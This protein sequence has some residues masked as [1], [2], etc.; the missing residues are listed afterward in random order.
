MTIVTLSFLYAVALNEDFIKRVDSALLVTK[1]SLDSIYKEWDIGHYPLF[2]RSCFM[3]KLA[4]E[5]MKLKFQHRMLAAAKTDKKEPT[6]FVISFTGSSVTAGHDSHFNKSTPIV[7]GDYLTPAFAAMD[8]ELDSRNVA[9]GNNPCTPYDV[10]V[11]FFAGLDADMVHWEQSYFCEGRPIIEQFIRQ[12]MA[13]P[14]KPLV[15][16]SESHTGKWQHKDCKDKPKSHDKLTKEEEDILRAPN[17]V[18]LVSEANKV[19]LQR[20]WKWMQEYTHAYHGAGLQLFEHMA[21]DVYACQGPYIPTW[22]EGAASWHPS[23]IGHRMRAAHHA[24]FWLLGWQEALQDLRNQS[25]HRVMEAMEKDVDHRL[26]KL[27]TPMGPARHKSEFPDGAN[28]YTDYEPRPVREASLKDRVVEGLGTN[29][30]HGW[31]FVIY[32]NLVDKNLVLKTHRMQYKDFKHLIYGNKDSGPLSLKIDLKE[33]GPIFICETP[34]IWGSLPKGFAHLWSPT[35]EVYMTANVEN[36]DNFKFN[37]ELGVKYELNYDK[38]HEIC[39]R[40]QPAHTKDPKI[41]AGNYVLTIVGRS[42]SKAIIAWII[43]P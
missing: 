31:K 25:S 22:M 13:M 27:I 10:C 4:W 32:E 15:I 6:K 18:Y 29:A 30:T 21:H 34:G 28:C 19:S 5:Q 2:L 41:K 23:V 36:R 16:F 33:D 38:K 14:S 39:T 17:P 26:N 40:I 11:K 37:P 43:T 1:D 3:H 8:I 20:R 42:E 12:A 35:V 7:A 9:L 24:Y